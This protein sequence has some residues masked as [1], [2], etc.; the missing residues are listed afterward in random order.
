[1]CLEE[2]VNF[3]ITKKYGWVV[4]FADGEPAIQSDPYAL[5]DKWQKDPNEKTIWGGWPEEFPY[6]TG[7]HIWTSKHAAKRWHT[8]KDEVIKKAY[9]RNVV[10]KGTQ[11]GHFVIVA[12]ERY[13]CDKTDKPLEEA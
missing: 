1:M 12:R 4:L 8:E 11:D 6:Q 9:F 5:F 3:K 10:A 13:V 7:F 2:L